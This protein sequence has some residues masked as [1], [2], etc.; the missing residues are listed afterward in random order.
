MRARY[1]TGCRGCGGTIKVGAEIVR[2]GGRWVHAGCGTGARAWK[3]GYGSR[4][5]SG[6]AS[7]AA[8]GVG[9][10]GSEVYEVRTSGGTFYRNRKGICEDAPCC[11]CCTF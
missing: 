2:S 3:S 5:H 4:L 1:A 11:G 10:G 9:E 6:S 7:E 8:K